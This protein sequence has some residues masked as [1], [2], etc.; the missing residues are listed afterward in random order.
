MSEGFAPRF[1]IEAAFLILLGVGAGYADLRTPVIV[2]IVAGG[3]VIVALIELSVWRSQ[4]RHSVEYAP[5][6]APAE[7]QSEDAFDDQAD[8]SALDDEYPLRAGAG[9]AP[10]EEIEAYTRILDGGESEASVEVEPAAP[11]SVPP[12]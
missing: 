12:S 7:E 3:W 5:P 10:S 11:P 8:V 9:D 4:T 6:P 1:A 2:G